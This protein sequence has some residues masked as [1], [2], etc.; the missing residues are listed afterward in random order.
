LGGLVKSYGSGLSVPDWPNTYGEFMFSF[1]YSKWVGGIFYEHLHRLFASFVGLQILILSF[2]IWKVDSRTWLKKLGFAALFTVILQGLLGGMT[3]I[4]LLPTLISMTHGILAQTFFCLT[5]AIAF[6]LSNNK[7]TKKQ[8]LSY[9]N[10]KFLKI[11]LLLT[12]MVY[13]QLILGAL[14][15]HTNSGLA[16]LDFPLSNGQL[17]PIPNESLQSSINYLRFDLG[18]NSVTLFQIIT[19]LLHRVG[20]I[21]VLLI[22]GI[23][24]IHT[25]RFHRNND[26]LLIPV[27]FT[28]LLVLTQIFLAAFVIWTRKSPIITTFHVW[29]GALILGSSFLLL[30]NTINLFEINKNLISFLFSKNTEKI[31]KNSLNN[32]FFLFIELSKPKIMWLVVLSTILGYY[33][34]SINNNLFSFN[35]VKLFFTIV[36]TIF[37]C[38]GSSILNQY[39]ERDLDKQMDRT[40]NRPLP[41]G[42]INPITA[43]SFGIYISALGVIIFFISVDF[44]VGLIAFLTLV[45]YVII[46]TPLKMQTNLNTLIGAVPGALPPLGGWVAGTGKI[47]LGALILFGILFFWQIPHFYSI[48][49]IYRKD[50]GQVGFKMLPV[51]DNSL[52]AT[53]FWCVFFTVL[54]IFTTCSLTWIGLTGQFFLFSSLFIGLVFL[55]FGIDTFS[56]W[57]IKRAKRL[58]IG[59]IIYLPLLLFILILD[60]SF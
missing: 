57:T 34:G 33:L 14:M 1:P 48:A 46:Y 41:S 44:L 32:L 52:K 6:Y 45:L 2:W 26:K 38:S 7:I 40:K 43:R 17:I 12:I 20:A 36:G 18:L 53:S 42:R 59:S 30:L 22:T 24:L 58:L 28:S 21:L 25:L 50:Y 31:N 60:K 39:L 11:V 13:V 37:V 9:Y 56:S 3:V 49:W 4:F 5:I 54:M 55:Y 27:L 10:S 23:L 19:H 51:N 29:T 15:R 35:L 47:E 16:I 8:K